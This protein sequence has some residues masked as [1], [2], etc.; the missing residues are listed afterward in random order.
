[1]KILAIETSTDFGTCAFWQDGVLEQRVCL[2]G[3]PHSETLLPLL[4]DLVADARFALDNLPN[5]IERNFSA[6]FAGDFR[7]RPV[8]IK[9]LIPIISMGRSNKK[10]AGEQGNQFKQHGDAPQHK[11]SSETLQ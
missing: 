9:M 1:M 4:R 6:P 3:R 2:S 7:H 5:T 11:K 10:T 8:A